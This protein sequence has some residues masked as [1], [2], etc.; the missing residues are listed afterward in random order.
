MVEVFVYCYLLVKDLFGG[1]VKDFGYESL[2]DVF[3]V[4]DVMFCGVELVDVIYDCLFD[5]YVDEEI[6]GIGNVWCIFVDD[7]VIIIDGIGIVY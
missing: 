3:V 6:Y 4:V 7:Y 2:E 1:Y 5:Y